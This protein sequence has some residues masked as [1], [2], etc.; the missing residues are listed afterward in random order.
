MRNR[1]DALRLRGP[2]ERPAS[3]G[4]IDGGVLSSA[5]CTLSPPG[6]GLSVT[7]A[8]GEMLIPGNEGGSQGGYYARVSTTSSV[9]IST[10]NPSLP[11]PPPATSCPPVS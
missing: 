8:T 5:D 2:R 1:P 6:S 4:I 11:R 7:I 3:P 10:A 9:S